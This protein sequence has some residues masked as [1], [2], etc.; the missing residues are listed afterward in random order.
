MHFTDIYK[1]VEKYQDKLYLQNVV[2]LST[3]LRFWHGNY[4]VNARKPQVVGAAT[5]DGGFLRKISFAGL[6]DR[7]DI[8][9][10]GNDFWYPIRFVY[11]SDKFELFSFL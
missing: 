2:P 6:G 1:E 11:F 5:E 8:M 4:F 3:F 7:T 10:F 9:F